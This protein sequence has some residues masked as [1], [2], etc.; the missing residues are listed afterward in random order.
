MRKLS[1]VLLAL[2]LIVL[3]GNAFGQAADLYK[4]KCQMCHGPDGKGQ[5]PA[6]KSMGAHDFSAP[7]VV[8]MTDKELTDV[9]VNGKN[10][11]PAFKGKLTDAQVKELVGYVRELQK[12][13]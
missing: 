8:K 4:S 9:T 2:S 3:A 1:I 5:T 12:K 10:K 13:K 7:D 6:G 11:M